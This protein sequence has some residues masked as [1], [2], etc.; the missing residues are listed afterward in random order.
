MNRLVIIDGHA[1]L[2]RA[3]HALP[4]L[5]TQKGQMVN[6]VYGFVSIL[7]RVIEE[8]KPTHLAVVFDTPKPTFRN[9]LS[10][11]YQANRPKTDTNLIPQFQLAHQVVEQMQIP[12][13]EMDGYEADDVIGTLVERT[14][15]ISQIRNPKSEIRNNEVII[16]TSDRDLFQLVSEHV[17]V[18][19]PVKG[20]SQSKLYGERDVEEKMGVGPGEIIDLKALIGDSSDNYPGIDGIGPKTAADLIKSFGSFNG[21]YKHIN[22]VKSRSVKEKLIKDKENGE[23]SRKLATIFKDVPIDFD[24]N[25]CILNSFDTAEVR[26][27]F[28]ELEFK[29]LIQ[30]LALNKTIDN[31]QH[32]TFNTKQKKNNLEDNQI[33]LF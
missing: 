22:E 28:E 27:L 31:I 30:R 29:S 26:W 4:S 11:E 20:I 21:I 24:L 17:K 33:S 1:L 14:T 13:F 7:L 8:L 5:T 15:N 23:L 19:M 25:K 32:S 6:A 2:H 18:Y 16:V 12:H 9:K 3:F 10:R